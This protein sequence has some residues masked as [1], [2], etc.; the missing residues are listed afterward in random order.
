MYLLT[1]F[2]VFFTFMPIVLFSIFDWE[3]PLKEM[4]MKPA[5][6]KEGR[7]RHELTLWRW[8]K[9]QFEAIVMG[10]T[11]FIMCFII[12]QQ[13]LTEDGKTS[14]MWLQGCLCYTS[15][16]FTV[17]WKVLSESNTINWIILFFD[18]GS[19]VVYFFFFWLESQISFLNIA[20]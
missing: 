14:G 8:L 18:F 19:I 7:N 4:V 16:V 15:V 12:A 6:F 17:T 20:G 9:W 13:D 5:M 1:L 10:A 3:L 11:T 2:N